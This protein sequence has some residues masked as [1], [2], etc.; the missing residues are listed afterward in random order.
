MTARGNRKDFIWEW[1]KAEVGVSQEKKKVYFKN[2][3]FK[4]A[5]AVTNTIYL[6][7]SKVFDL[8]GIEYKESEI[9]I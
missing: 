4:G 2:N 3:S 7:N 5:Q 9:G 1:T 6:K 8:V